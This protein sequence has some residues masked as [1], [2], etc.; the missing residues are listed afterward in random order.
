VAVDAR[1]GNRDPC[2]TAPVADGVYWI[3]GIQ[4]GRPLDITVE[5]KGYE[6]VAKQVPVAS[7]SPGSIE[8]VME[9]K[10]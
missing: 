2:Y 10:K 3:A 9:R 1:Q 8:L 7:G 4:P 5:K 6:S